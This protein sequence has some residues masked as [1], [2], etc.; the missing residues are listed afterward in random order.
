[1]RATGYSTQSKTIG[2]V[3]HMLRDS[4]RALALLSIST[5]TQ[6]LIP[7]SPLYIQ[8][9]SHNC[10]SENFE[11][12]QT[13]FLRWYFSFFSKPFWL[14]AHCTETLLI[15]HSRDRK[16]C[17]RVKLDKNWKRSAKWGEKMVH[18]TPTP[19]N[20][21]S[22]PSKKIHAG[23]ILTLILFSTKTCKQET[24]ANKKGYTYKLFILHKGR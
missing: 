16:S 11:F 14:R 8:Y 4:S 22:L 1:M 13:K 5:N 23:S 9:N 18:R 21:H 6:D 7:D 12:N 20:I 3:V 2:W 10:S 24:I 17:K 19:Q 15:Y